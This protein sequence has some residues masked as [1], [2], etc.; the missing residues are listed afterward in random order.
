MINNRGKKI[1]DSQ[2]WLYPS[3]AGVI[4]FL[5]LSVYAVGTDFISGRAAKSEAS[6]VAAAE[7]QTI[8]ANPVERGCRAYAIMIEA[9]NPAT[10]KINAAD[11]I[12]IIVSFPA[13]QEGPARANTVVAGARVI[14][15]DSKNRSITVSVTPAEAEKLAFSQTN[16]QIR[17]ALCPAGPD[18]AIA[19]RGAT[20]ESL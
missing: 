19:G 14:S 6:G 8:V 15:V 10:S 20:F 13:G 18:T 9:D 3:L 7:K 4:T 1:G 16:G 5:V 11:K 17:I 12:D 2:P